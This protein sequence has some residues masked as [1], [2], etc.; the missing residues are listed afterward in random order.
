MDTIN[1]CINY[2]QAVMNVFAEALD[3]VRN[4]GDDDASLRPLAQSL[5]GKYQDS[6]GGHQEI[7]SNMNTALEKCRKE[8][9]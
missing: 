3:K 9:P 6:K 5:K 4:E 8:R 2:R 1:K 7:I